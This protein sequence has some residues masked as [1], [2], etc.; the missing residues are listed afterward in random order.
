MSIKVF[1]IIFLKGKIVNTTL[2]LS[3]L[4]QQIGQLF[5]AG[6]PD[7]FLDENTL[8]LIRDYNIGGLILFSRNIEGPIQLAGLCKDI[9]AAAV[10]YNG[11]QIFLAIDQEGGRV[12]RLKKPFTEFPG[13]SAIGKDKKPVARA[14]EIGRVMAREMKM[15]GLNMNL[16]PVVDVQRGELERH[17]MGRAFGEDPLEVSLLG[18][19]VIGSLQGNGIMAVAKHFPGLGR[20]TMDPHFNLPNIDIDI[21]ELEEINL[22]PFK[23]AVDEDVSAIMTSHAIYKVLDPKNPATLSYRII[24]ELLRD[25]IGFRGLIITDDLEMGAIKSRWSVPEGAA[26]AFK[27]G[28]DILLICEN[29]DEVM[30]SIGLLRNMVLKGQISGSRLNQSHDRIRAVR[31]RFLKRR[32]K[33]SMARVNEYFKLSA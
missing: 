27:A 7:T 15:V 8:G 33:I 17:L 28:A 26:E 31:N 30:N 25:E 18:R 20:T 6:M 23:A 4:N 22:P 11:H 10:R 2:E 21:A 16:A 24:T 32:R 1:L 19:T 14:R 9:Q 12:A 5:M 3:E 29:Q 13:N